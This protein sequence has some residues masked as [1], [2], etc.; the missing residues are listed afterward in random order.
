MH[1]TRCQLRR[2]GLTALAFAGIAPLVTMPAALAG[3]IRPGATQSFPDLSG[4]IVGTQTYQYDPAT[5]TG[6]FQVD[7]TPTVLATGPQAGG[8]FYINDLPAQARSQVLLVK[9][10]GNGA[11]IADA[12]NHYSLYGSTTVGGTTYSGLLLQGTPTQFGAAMPSAATP[13]TSVY[14]A[15]IALT[16]GLLKP[17]Y[18]DEA[19]LRVIAETN[20]TFTGVFD[21]NFVGLKAMT[22]VRSY[23]APNASPIPEPSTCLVVLACGGAG[24]LFRGRLR[25]PVRELMP[26]PEA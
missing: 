15:N 25:V 17:A 12:G 24:L 21:Q 14:D 22:N 19:Y 5:R 3:L 4:D 23:D 9:L 2:V 16:G 1:R 6:T 18:G 20:S 11:L 7:N 13:G 10:D 26:P 8:E